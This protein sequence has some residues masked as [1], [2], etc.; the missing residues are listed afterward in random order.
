MPSEHPYNVE[1][2]LTDE[3]K[4]ESFYTEG[5]WN[6]E[7]VMADAFCSVWRKRRVWRLRI[8]TALIGCYF[9]IYSQNSII[10][11][12]SVQIQ[13]TVSHGFFQIFQ[14]LSATL[15]LSVVCADTDW[16]SRTSIHAAET[17][18]DHVE[19]L[20]EGPHRRH[21]VGNIIYCTDH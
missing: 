9:S 12:L 4:L 1:I 18:W 6:T 17:E 15:T 10:S 2:D 3:I 19:S 14:F 21:G 13:Q 7:N 8:L 20:N 11:K 16:L 5:E